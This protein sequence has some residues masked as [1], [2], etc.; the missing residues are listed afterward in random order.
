[1]IPVIFAAALAVLSPT[2]VTTSHFATLDGH[3]VHYESAGNG[4]RTVVFVHG[5]SC[6]WTVWREQIPVFASK[7]R[8]LAL[9]LPGH[10][11]SDAPRIDYT[12]DLFARAVDAVLRDA[13]ISHA[14]LVGHSMGTPVVRQFYRR[15]PEK[16][17]ALVAVDGSFRVLFSGAEDREKFLAPYRGSEYKERLE[18]FADFMFT[19]DEKDLADQMKSVMTKTPQH[20]LVSAAES[21]L[22]PANFKE[23]PIRVPLLALLAKSPLWTE[24][25]EAFVRRLAPQVDY[26]VME[27][28]RHFLMLEKPDEFNAVLASFLENPEK[29]R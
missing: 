15:Y 17:D 23:D 1:M 16:T 29:R 20:V 19:P 12:M 4:P 14:V 13:G 6:D 28:V 7:A 27:G 24:E 22:D 5:W 8:V 9:D 18:R 26:R 2:P 21:M 10:G 25:Y 11:R 3:R